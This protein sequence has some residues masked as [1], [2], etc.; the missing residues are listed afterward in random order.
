MVRINW[1]FQA[2]EDLKSIADYIA[3]DSKNYAKMQ[4]MRIKSRTMILKSQI[5]NQYW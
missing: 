1:T 5:S 4:V 2:K 3:R